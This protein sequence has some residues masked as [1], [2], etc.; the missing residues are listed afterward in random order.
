MTLR[1]STKAPTGSRKTSPRRGWFVFGFCVGFVLV[2]A[3]LLAALAGVLYWD[4]KYGES[5]KG[6][7]GDP[8]PPGHTR[9]P[10]DVT[11]RSCRLVN[12]EP[13]AQLRVKNRS[14]ALAD[15]S[16]IVRFLHEGG[17]GFAEDTPSVDVKRLA[18]GAT[19]EITVTGS[20]DAGLRAPMTCDVSPF[21]IVPPEDLM[22]PRAD[23][24]RGNL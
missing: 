16:V 24:G 20:A 22:E 14:S 5:T 4:D 9:V 23:A 6:F 2:P 12:G 7:F 17:D 21:R 1:R 19:R 13:Q 11:V 3:A 8:Y 10:R 15:Y 18:P